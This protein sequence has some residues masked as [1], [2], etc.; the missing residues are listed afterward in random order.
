MIDTI[1]EAAKFV[2]RC[3]FCDYYY[4]CKTNA[5]C[6]ELNIITDEDDYCD[7]FSLHLFRGLRSNIVYMDDLDNYH[8]TKEEYSNDRTSNV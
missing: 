6:A 5:M 3:G 1:E 4:K 7:K 2:K 8:I